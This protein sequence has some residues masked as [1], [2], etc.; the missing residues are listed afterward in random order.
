MTPLTFFYNFDHSFYLK[1]ILSYRLF[2]YDLFYHLPLFECD[3]KFYIF[4]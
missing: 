2:C 4:K 3:L 1:K